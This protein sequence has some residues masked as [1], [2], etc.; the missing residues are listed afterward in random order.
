MK[1]ALP[2]LFSGDFRPGL[3]VG[4]IGVVLLLGLLAGA[5]GAVGV[6][7]RRT[8]SLSPFEA[9][10]DPPVSYLRRA[11]ERE[12][13]LLAQE[14]MDHEDTFTDHEYTFTDHEDSGGPAGPPSGLQ[15]HI[16]AWDCF[17]AALLLV[18]GDRDALSRPGTE[19]ADLVAVAVLARAGRAALAGDVYDRCCGANPL[20]GPAR[21]PDGPDPRPV[22]Q[23]CRAVAAPALTLPTGEGRDRA[24][25]DEATGPLPAVRDGIAQLILTVREYASVQ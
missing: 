8:P 15:P 22:C 25:Y 24:P 12:L 2:P 4:G 6:T 17:D 23:T 21:G 3:L 11:A 14:F 20:H 18:D 10:A 19:P 16:R 5:L 9:P 7:R 13:D 1:D